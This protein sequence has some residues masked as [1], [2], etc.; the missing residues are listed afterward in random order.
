MVSEPEVID[1]N[2]RLLPVFKPLE[3]RCIHKS[4]QVLCSSWNPGCFWRGPYNA[5]ERWRVSHKDK[6]ICNPPKGEAGG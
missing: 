4:E 6:K 1:D 2:G 5:E 3:C